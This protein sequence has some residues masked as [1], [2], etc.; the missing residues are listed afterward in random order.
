MAPRLCK[1][2]Q[3]G[4]EVPF[5]NPLACCFPFID[6]FTGATRNADFGVRPTR[7]ARTAGATPYVA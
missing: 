4:N 2:S 1:S 7:P 3:I 5:K 6:F